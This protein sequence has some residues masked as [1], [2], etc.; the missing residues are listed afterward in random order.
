MA[1]TRYNNISGEQT[2][3]MLRAGDGIYVSKVSMA[4]T[5]A[6]NAVTVDLF[7]QKENVGK[8]YLFKGV[9]MPALT[10]LVYDSTIDTSDTGYSLFIKLTKS[11]SETPTVDVI[12]Y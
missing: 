1:R 4:N 5:N 2:T 10:S 7:L 3:E 8:Y 9:S 12:L 6:A 11:A